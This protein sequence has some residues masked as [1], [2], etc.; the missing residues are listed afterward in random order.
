LS[1]RERKKKQ[2]T[3]KCRIISRVSLKFLLTNIK[4]EIV[5]LVI[6]KISIV[7]TSQTMYVYTSYVT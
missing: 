2:N 1:K 6:A 5:M 7:N 4:K 3:Y